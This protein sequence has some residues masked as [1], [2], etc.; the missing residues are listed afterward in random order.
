[1]DRKE[2]SF[3]TRLKNENKFFTRVIEKMTKL[4][5]L[6]IEE[7]SYI[8]SL[9]ILFFKEYLESNFN[10][11][12]EFSY[13]LVLFYSLQTKDYSPLLDFSFNNGFFPIARSILVNCEKSIFTPLLNLEISRYRKENIVELKEQKEK[14]E[15]LTESKEFY[16]AF[17][18]PTS[19]GKSSFILEDISKHK[20]NIIGIIVPK[21][22]L[23]WQSFRNIKNLAKE[24]SYKVLLHDSE[25]MGEK[26]FIGIFTQERATR[27]I[28]DSDISFDVLYIDEAHNIFEKDERSILLARLIKLNKKLNINHKVIYL[29]PLIKDIN[30]LKI[31]NQDIIDTQKISFNI[32]EYNIRY[33]DKNCQS[34]VYNRFVDDFYQM[35]ESYKNWF[36]YII[37]T[38]KNKNLI[39]LNKPRDIEQFS[40]RFCK[41]FSS[42][43][44]KELNEIADIIEK[45]VDK[46]YNMVSLIRCGILYIHS[47]IPDIIKDYLLEK[48]KKCLHIKYLISNSTVFEG[49]NFPIDNLYIFNTWSLN[50]N[51]LKNLCGRVNRLN[52][53]F[54]LP[55]QLDKLI[56][57]IN[58][59][60][61]K[62]FGGTNNF[63]NK[64]KLLRC[65]EEDDVQNPL[66]ENSRLE[67]K[68][69]KE[70]KDTEESFIENPKS[71]S[72]KSILVKNNVN[73]FYKNFDNAINKIESQLAKANLAD[74]IDSLFDLIFSIFLSKFETD[75]IS[76]FEFIRLQNELTRN[77]YKNYLNGIYYSNVKSKVSYFLK[78]FEYFE[79]EN[80]IFYIGKSFGEI[81]FRSDNY[82]GNNNAY[83]NPK[84]KSHSEKVNLAV[85]KSKIEDDFVD[86][87]IQK[88]VKTLLDLELISNELF[89]KFLYN[90][91]DEKKTQ[92]MSMGLSRQLFA[93]IE[94]NN[95]FDDVNISLSGIEVSKRFKEVL[96]NQDDL[97]RFEIEK[98]I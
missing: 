70:I 11:Y 28:Q 66:L 52:E 68:K 55:P 7:S 40:K 8:L 22:A 41:N 50:A 44:E 89:N 87:K 12:F 91:T 16:R 82:V 17:I 58:F 86:F 37:K 54:T 92:L 21:K 13:Y 14:I 94:E 98:F 27:L 35:E 85:I 75:E 45:Y 48:F 95:L 26:R 76:D 34:Y 57:P 18:A 5:T 51:N 33:Y 23:I 3:F 25:Y 39:F 97:I 69:R 90:T 31:S 1:M 59:I 81:P 32:K 2:K 72:L 43:N 65:D 63:K 83:I 79:Q 46:D 78:Y 62:E 93:F 15:K 73:Q 30:N 6:N 36:E 29:S 77:F 53:I 74:S 38:S 42:L 19:Y 10:A 9:S 60:E 64:I 47:K 80:M 67:D 61:T 88:L 20:A 24:L 71:K 56:C 49:V 4:K 84:G 96:M